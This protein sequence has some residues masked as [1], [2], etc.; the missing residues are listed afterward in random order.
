[1]TMVH[2]VDEVLRDREHYRAAPAVQLLFHG[3]DCG[4]YRRLDVRRFGRPLCE[5]ADRFGHVDLLEALPAARAALDLADEREHRARIGERGVDAYGE[6]RAADG[7]RAEAG[8]GA[9]GQ[10]GVRLGHERCRALVPCRDD[11]DA[12]RLEALEE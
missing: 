8:C 7:A 5:P 11:V 3:I 6:I 2:L 10:L 12:D 1:P 9:T 4:L